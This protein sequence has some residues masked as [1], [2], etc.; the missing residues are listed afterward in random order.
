MDSCH[1]FAVPPWNSKKVSS[2]FSP[3]D[4]KNSKVCLTL[5]LLYGFENSKIWIFRQTSKE[6][7]T[8]KVKK[9]N[10]NMVQVADP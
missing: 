3:N 4:P 5:F 2:A 10:A 7:H 1:F 9:G 6:E 8:L